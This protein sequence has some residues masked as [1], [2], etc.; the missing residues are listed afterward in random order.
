MYINYQ[1]TLELE[2]WVVVS[3]PIWEL[4]TELGSSVSQ[5]STPH[6]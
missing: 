2:F 5:L 3:C 4:G 1:I 6:S